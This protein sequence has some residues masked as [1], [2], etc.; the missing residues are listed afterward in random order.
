MLEFLELESSKELEGLD[1]DLEAVLSCWLGLERIS[2][3]SWVVREASSM[4]TH[5][6]SESKVRHVLGLSLRIDLELSGEDF[7]EDFSITVLVPDDG[8]EWGRAT[9]LSLEMVMTSL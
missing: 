7:S 8:E 6:A 1:E 5:S 2:F 3:V 4:E 9:S